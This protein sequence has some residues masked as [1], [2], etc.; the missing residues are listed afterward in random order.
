MAGLTFGGYR[1]PVEF[2]M[3]D[4]HNGTIET[5]DNDGVRALLVHVHFRLVYLCG[6]V[7]ALLIGAC[8]GESK[9]PDNAFAIIANQDLG[10]GRGRLLVAIGDDQGSR[11]GSPDDG[12][13][14]EVAP[15]GNPAAV[16]SAP[17]IWT[18]LLPQVSGL[19]RAQF[20]FN[21]PGMWVA[22]V[23]PVDGNPLAEV[24]FDVAENSSAPAVGE[25]API[26]PT[27]TLD[28]LPIEQLTTDTTP[29]VTFYA[30]SL[31]DALASGKPTV[32][33]FSTPAYC[34][35]AMCGPLLDIV[36]QVAPQYP[37]INFIHVEVFTEF[38]IDGFSPVSEFVAQSA[39]PGGF[40][41]ISEPWVFV[42]SSD[43]V[44]IGRFEGVLAPEEL[45]P[46]LR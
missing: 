30:I 33:V 32:L 35:T 13:I 24:L 11:L 2:D 31:D 14:I 3:Q 34:Q 38:W 7:L 21:M 18:W 41:L 26:V 16:Q 27:P 29:D 39:G 6:L 40:R 46:L 10:S 19:Y 5:P 9:F 45:S 1:S 15:V 25:H 42:I 12:I 23:A 17:G 44:I 37:D 28:V 4:L 22:T 36:Q 20:D 8:G 43:G